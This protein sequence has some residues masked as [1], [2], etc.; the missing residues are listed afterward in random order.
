M[1]ERKPLSALY[2]PCLQLFGERLNF[3]TS[4]QDTLEQTKRPA[5]SFSA[6]VLS[7][8]TWDCW[9]TKKSWHFKVDF[10]SESKLLHCRSLLDTP[11]TPSYFWRQKEIRFRGS[12]RKRKDF[13]F[14]KCL[15]STLNASHR[16]GSRY[17]NI[18]SLRIWYILTMGV[19]FFLFP[20]GN[21][22]KIRE[23]VMGNKI[24]CTNAVALRHTGISNVSRV[25]P[26]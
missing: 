4:G 3:E 1:N 7:I 14:L 5:V 15:S 18:S 8:S 24:R 23:L 2:I 6:S 9:S 10:F 13:G 11:S 22:L 19:Y 25:L 16:L 21:C 17:I 12:G 26:C 20:L